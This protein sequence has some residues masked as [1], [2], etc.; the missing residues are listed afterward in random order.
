MNFEDVIGQDTV[1]GQLIRL[2]EEGR[3]PH[4][5]LLT[6]P[7]GCGKLPLAVAFACRLLGD[8]GMTRSLAHPDLHFT[9][10]TIKQPGMSSEYQPTSDDYINE[11]R[12]LLLSD[13]Y[14]TFEQWMAAMG[15]ANQQ[16]IITGGESDRL[17]QR[18]SLK[19]SQGGWKI[20]IIWLP[21]RTNLTS[22]NKLLKL[23][24]E[25]PAE[26]L[27]LLVSE[28]PEK[29]LETILSRTQRLTLKR[30]SDADME[31]ALVRK[32]GLDEATARSLARVAGGNWLKAVEQLDTD[33][34]SHEFLDIFITLMRQAYKRDVKSLKAWSERLAAMGREKQRRFLAYAMR[35]VRESF[36][37][38][39]QESD[40]NYM[41]V[42]EEQFTR[43]FA[44]FIN[45]ANVIG[46]SEIMEKAYRDIGQNANAKI[47]F[48]DLAMDIIILLIKK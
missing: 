6:G 37:C 41:T 40:L 32:R 13:P 39:F 16:A 27:F 14:F 35:M 42:Q 26:T 29:I 19:S 36:M 10:P 28:A 21:E 5:M 24:E 33:S 44:R 18:L 12:Q 25:P 8:N 17:A 47:V 23:L 22:A 15:A 9:F 4:A 34:E 38:N 2:A 1:K 20:S 43:N 3:L 7:E 30:I 46:I 45:E 31:E 48:F 11:W